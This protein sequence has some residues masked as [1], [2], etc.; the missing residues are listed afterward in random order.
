MAQQHALLLAAGCFMAGCADD[1]VEWGEDTADLTDSATS[2]HAR[3]LA[4]CRE[5]FERRDDTPSTDLDLLVDSRQHAACLRDVNDAVL[6]SIER[7]LE[8]VRSPLSGK[9]AGRFAA[10]RTVKVCEAVFGEGTV[11]LET[12]RW[13]RE[14]LLG[15]LIDAVVALPGPRVVIKLSPDASECFRSG[16]DA[17]CVLQ[18][19]ADLRSA[20][21]AVSQICEPLSHA[22]E[23]SLSPAEAPNP[24]TDEALRTCEVAAA[25]ALAR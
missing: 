17:E 9:V 19:R 24:T 8:G 10:Y 7:N 22:F 16:Q 13:E 20:F 15:N 21:E 25:D 3:G 1:T 11:A 23:R 6:P 14:A 18:G 4:E 2:P 5:V 12:C